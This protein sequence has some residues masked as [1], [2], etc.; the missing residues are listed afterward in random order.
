MHPELQSLLRKRIE[1]IGDHSLRDKDPALHLE[2]LKD[3]S[4]KIQQYGVTN[5]STFDGK[6]KHY[7]AQS[8][9]QKA[10]EHLES[11]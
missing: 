2:A 10:L 4:E 7:M 11:Q 3:V 6:L 1:V 9:Y 5:A 8:S